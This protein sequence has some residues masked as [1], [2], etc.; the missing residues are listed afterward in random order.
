MKIVAAGGGSG[1]HVT[2]V[3][4]VVNELKKHDPQL[5]VCFVT[6]YM[7]GSRA[8][9]IMKKATMPVRVKQ[10]VAGKFRRYHRVSVWRQLL[11]VPTTLQNIR[12]L[13]YAGFGVLQSLVL[14][15]RYKPDVIFTKGGFVCVP[16]GIAAHILRIP[17]VIHDSDAHPGLA[18]RILARWATTIATGSPL[19]NYNYPKGR[20]HYVGIPIDASF[21]PVTAAQQQKFKANLGL[22][23]TKKPLLVV[24]GGGL[25]ARNIN[26]AI[27]TIAPQLVDTVAIMHITVEQTYNEIL[28]QAPEHIDYMVKPFI[29]TGMA[30]LFGAADVVVTRAGATTMQELAAMAKPVIIVPNP[31]L[32]GGHQLKNAAVYQAAKAAVVVDEERLVVNPLLLK[33]AVLTLV[34]QPEKSKVL[35]RRLQEFARPEAAVDMAALIVEAAATHRHQ[36][37]AR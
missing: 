4:A 3:L 35:G 18:N 25:G 15:V 5:E 37:A 11:D 33:K 6:D 7:F 21:Q 8:K 24:T 1:G 2:P 30:P 22:H 19:E 9:A 10:I 23:D 34:N 13:F 27:V 12:D 29:S 16:L 17:I 14:L 26:R 31:L 20:S 36:E 32:T 28:A